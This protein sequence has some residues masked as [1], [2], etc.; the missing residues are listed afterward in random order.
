MAGSGGMRLLV[1]GDELIDELEDE[2]QKE[3]CD[4]V[5]LRSKAFY[6]IQVEF[7]DDTGPAS[8]KLYWESSSQPKQIVPSSAYYLQP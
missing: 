6:D 2:G 7:V 5:S 8:L 4:R 3:E 1:D